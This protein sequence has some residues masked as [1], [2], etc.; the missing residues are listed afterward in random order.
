M[1]GLPD[2]V[3]KFCLALVPR[4]Y[5]PVMGI[6]CKKW[7]S[8]IKSKEFNIVRKEAGKLEEWLYVLTSDNEAKSSHWEVLKGSLMDERM[9]LPP[10]PGPVK[11]GFGTVAV[12]GKLLIMAG[13]SVD[14]GTECVSNDVYEYDCLLNSWTKLASMA[15]P[16]FD[17][18]CTELNGLI[19][20]IGGYSSTGDSL[21]SVEVYDPQTNKWAPAPSLHR[22]RWGCFACS[23]RSH[24]FV[25][26]GRCSFTIG[27]P[28]FVDVYAPTTR[29]WA[30]M[31]GG[32]VMVTAHAVI[33]KRLFCM[34][35]K[36]QRKL[37]VF[38]MEEGRWERVEVPVNGSS[39][40]GFRFGVLDGRLY[41]F[42][43]KEDVGSRSL[44]YDPGAGAR[45]RWTTS[46][47][48]PKGVCLGCVTIQA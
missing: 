2:D 6:V 27:H 7:R 41:M 9:I 21:S 14:I 16:R 34:E 29:S 10:M 3:S 48:K 4:K 22:P 47:V 12:N 25:L 44:V 46:T 38:D 15:T 11:A 23:H 8:F 32:C 39:A 5:I 43:T 24:L 31:K 18:A 20:V 42:P 33:G 36:S 1:P 37:A 28:K 19:Y 40:L 17:F 45:L 13:Y 26:G 30:E 35:W